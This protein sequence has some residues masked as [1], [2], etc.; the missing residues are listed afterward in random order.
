[1][2]G[3]DPGVGASD[4]ERLGEGLIAQP[5]NTWSSLAFVVVGVVIVAVA[6]SELRQSDRLFGLLLVAIGFGSMAFHGPQ[7]GVA[8]WLHDAPIVVLLGFVLVAEI[9]L[10]RR[11]G[12]LEVR[13]PARPWMLAAAATLA[14]GAVCW[15][16]GRTDAVLCSPDSLVQLH[17][18]WHV[19][20]AVALGCWWRSWALRSRTRVALVDSD[21]RVSG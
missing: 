9:R 14:L 1:M 13:R 5:V 15:R 11:F 18:V 20:A 3:I 10:R 21:A 6:R 7:P 2:S 19:L 12:V 8:R 17:A 16:T 4:C